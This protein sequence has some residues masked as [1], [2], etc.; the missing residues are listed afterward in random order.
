[1]AVPLTTA[2]QTQ[3]ANL[4]ISIL[5]RNPDPVGF[6]YWCDVYANANGTQ[7][8]LD[9]IASGF[10]KSPEFT[11]IY[12][13]QTTANAVALMY[14][15]ILGRTQ[16]AGG[17]AYWTGIA[18]GYITS[19]RTVGDAY[20]LTANAMITAAAANTGT[21]DAT[22][23]ASKQTAAVAAGTAAPT[24]T[25]TLTTNA[26]TFGNEFSANKQIFDGSTP[27]SLSAFDVLT[28]G[29]NTADTL[30]AQVTGTAL[31]AA[32]RI[33][34]VELININTTGAGFTL[35]TTAT[36]G[37]TITGA[38]AVNVQSST[39]GAVAITAATTT[40]VSALATGNGN[41]T[42]VGSGGAFVATAGTGNVTI[43]GTAVANAITSAT[44]T[45]GTAVAITDR[46]GASAATG[47]RLTTVT[48]QDATAGA[49]G[50]TANGIT[51]LNLNRQTAN[52]ADATITAAAGTRALTV[53]LNGVVAAAGTIDITDA[54]ATTLTVNS[55]TAASSLYTTVAGA[56]TTVNLNNAVNSSNSALTAGVA[57]AVNISGAGNTTVLTHTLA[58]NA[59]ITSTATGNVT[60]ATL[61]AGQQ[62]NGTN[63]S[64]VDT[65]T[66]S[67]SGT[68][69]I[70]TG[71]G[72]DVVTYAGPMGAG[73]SVD[74]GA[75]TAD[76]IVMTLAQAVVATASTTFRGTIS[77]FEILSVG[78]TAADGTI[79]MANAGTG[80]NTVTS[81]GGAHVI[82]INNAA[83]NFTFNQTALLD[84]AAGSVINYASTTGT[85]TVNFGFS[86]TDG[87][88]NAQTL[89]VA[90]V[91]VVNITTT[92]TAA[93]VAATA[94]MVTPIVA[95]SATTV[96]ISGNIGV[97]LAGSNLGTALTTL[98]ASGLTLAN[99]FGGLTFTSGALA[100]ASTIT[101]S[102]AGT[103]VVTVTAALAAVTYTGG[104][105]A[106]TLVGPN[107]ANITAN[108]GNGTNGYSIAAWASGNSNITGGTGV[109][110][111]TTGGGAD[112]I[113]A[114]GGNDI[115]AGGAGADSIDGGTGIDTFAA[116]GMLGAAIDGAGTGTSTG[117]VVNLS[118]S[119]VTA[120]A[121]NAASVTA[122]TAGGQ[123]ISGALTSVAAGSAT[124]IFNTSSN[125]FSSAVD[126]LTSIESVTGSTGRDYIWA[127]AAGGGT[128]NAGTGADYMVAG[129][130]VDTF[131]AGIAGDSIVA[132]AQTLANAA[133]ANTNTITF[134]N[135]LDV[136]TGFV[137]GQ[138]KLDVATAGVAATSGI[139]LAGNLDLVANTTYSILGTWNSA[140]GV[141]T[142]NSAA[143]SSTANVATLIV[144]GDAGALT[145]QD[146]T[147]YT[148][149]VGVAS[150][151]AADFV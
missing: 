6:G 128:I 57:T 110:T 84:T 15:N 39:Q 111:I 21:A 93:T 49:I 119:A 102:V 103:N 151:V 126:T 44:V 60:F 56:A 8:A 85:N 90:G 144:V 53:N 5:G 3:I 61:L 64:G 10:G 115:L 117:V 109:D 37:S 114:S 130:G 73:G 124:Y 140:T 81:A 9:A 32:I 24:T 16:D 75:G 33:T 71:D 54:T 112:T 30:N 29:T 141:F 36:T 46:S 7:A 63:S 136:I 35:D 125:L 91:E 11:G 47:S 106:D 96:N 116:T 113:V 82:T 129:A 133:I 145:F 22:L 148:L 14:N 76:T 58:A 78:A 38:T 149:L 121:I 70:T 131:T 104:S 137:S 80:V 77:N 86:A 120:A 40:S 101:G 150:T 89:T 42:V 27:D 17:A 28:G 68:T 65:I 98:N 138:D 55:V 147:G 79:N 88:T 143:T 74:A 87:F 41:I 13:G 122:V 25:Y 97:S 31:A 67:A 118:S 66:L 43:G 2:M 127:S 142:V 94:V 1:M 83:E 134:G 105:G 62:Y 69:A 50:I 132:S 139:G 92:D 146:T 34:G 23:I 4:Y 26:N 19:G 100:G 135:G 48:V 52:A 20:A 72:N 12:S 108:L 59:V 123:F 45:G 99:A 51:T 107:A 18:N 95:T